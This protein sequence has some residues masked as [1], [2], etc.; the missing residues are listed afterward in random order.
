MLVVP[1]AEGK[2]H[3]LINGHWEVAGGTGKLKGL[4]GAGTV[5]VKVV[6]P[7]ERHWIL[8]GDLS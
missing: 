2:P 6:S 1:G 4:R 5:H 3:P 7:K 8:E